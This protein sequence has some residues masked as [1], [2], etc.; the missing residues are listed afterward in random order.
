VLSAVE[1]TVRGSALWA[2]HA[3]GPFWIEPFFGSVRLSE[4]SDSIANYQLGFGDAQRGLGKTPY[5]KHVR[6]VD[7]FFPKEWLFTFS[8]G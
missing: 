5:G 6:R 1:L 4:T 7:W 2:K 8:K 3:P